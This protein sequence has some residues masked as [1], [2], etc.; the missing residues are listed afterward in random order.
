MSVEPFPALEWICE[1]CGK[2]NFLSVVCRE[3]CDTE[4][5]AEFLV[6]PP[7]TVV[8]GHCGLT[9]ETE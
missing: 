2:N 5:E 3:T 7:D 9:C 6:T 4:D 8:C 1:H